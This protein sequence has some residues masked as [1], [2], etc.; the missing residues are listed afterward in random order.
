[1]AQKKK[2]AA[3]G[4]DMSSIE[5]VYAG[6]PLGRHTLTA[7]SL[8]ADRPVGSCVSVVADQ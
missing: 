5:Q 7:E 3:F 1:M 6:Q 8:L 2:T 4:S